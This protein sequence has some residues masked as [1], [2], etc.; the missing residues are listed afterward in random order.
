MYIQQASSYAD[1]AVWGPY[2]DRTRRNNKF[3]TFVADGLSSYRQIELPGPENWLA[4]KASWRV[5]RVALIGMQLVS[6]GTLERYEKE[7]DAV[8]AEIMAEKDRRRL[9]LGDHVTF[10]FENRRTA[11]YQVQEMLRTE[12]IFED[13]AIQ[14]ELDTYNELVPGASE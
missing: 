4:W 14:H 9:E 1:F 7:R 6:F 12:R 3:R 11:W 2:N 5:F 13:T 10:L 8:R